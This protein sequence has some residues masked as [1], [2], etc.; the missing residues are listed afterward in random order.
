MSLN[1]ACGAIALVGSGEYLPVMTA[2]EGELLQVAVARGRS[3]LFL[4]LPTAAGAE[5]EARLAHWHQLGKE[6]ADRLGVESRS[7]PLY[8]RGDAFNEEFLEMIEQAGL[9]YLSGGDPH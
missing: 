9:I 8:N 7:L 1:P 5:S 6:Q 3:P 2:L 4:Q